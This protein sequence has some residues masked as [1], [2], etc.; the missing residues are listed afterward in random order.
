MVSQQPQRYG[1]EDRLSERRGG[2]TDPKVNRKEKDKSEGVDI[3]QAGG[4][5]KGEMMYQGYRDAP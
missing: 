1:E 2:V 5:E 3:S 4:K